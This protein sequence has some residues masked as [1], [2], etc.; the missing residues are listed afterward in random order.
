MKKIIPVV[1][2]LSLLVGC[3]SGTDMQKNTATVFAMDTVMTL[4]AYGEEAA[5]EA[6]LAEAKS[7]LINLDRQL[8]V[9]DGDSEIA[10]IN[11]MRY[12]KLTGG[13][14]ALLER[15][16][17]VAEATAGAYDPTVYPLM[18]AWGFY[19]DNYKI[20]GAPGSL[21]LSN[22]LEAV[23]Y[24]RV[25]L[26]Y[27]KEDGSTGV[28][29]A[30]EEPMGLDLGGI[31]K[32]YAAEEV[33]RTMAENGIDTAVISLGGNVGLMGTKADG[34]DWVVAVEKPDGSGEAIAEMRIPGGEKNT[35][36][37]TSG[38]YQRYFEVDGVR[39]HHIL[40]P[41]T[42][43]PA[44]TDLLSVT[45]ISENGAEADALST[46]LFVMGFEEAVSYW[47][48]HAGEFDVVLITGDGIFASAGISIIGETPVAALEVTE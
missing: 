40:D 11:L 4:T 1:L 2:I 10:G 34:S 21:E 44:E 22:L 23:G 42:G 29:F 16:L 6:A 3:T 30:G 43:Y 48:Q 17:V 25:E 26:T 18:R 35:Y 36:V 5:V 7:V 13:A 28:T 14:G 33:L 45:I 38:A 9:T 47:R 24:D 12:G 32:G 41:E 8:S 39:Y 31:A 46:A 19:D 27:Q 20:P 15:A 37:V